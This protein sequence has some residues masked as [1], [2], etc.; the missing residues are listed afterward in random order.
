MWG[1]PRGHNI[2][3]SGSHFYETYRTQDGGY[4]SVGAI[5][6][7]FYQRLLEGLGVTE[8]ELPQFEDFDKLKAKL[9][10]I[11]ATKTRAEWTEIFGRITNSYKS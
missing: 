6:P 9:A 4:M 5:E 2:L 3:D 8:D 7:Q 10:E 1:E 11:F